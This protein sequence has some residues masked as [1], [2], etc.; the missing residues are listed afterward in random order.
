MQH[1]KINFDSNH[2]TNSS[3]SKVGTDAVCPNKLIYIL[4]YTHER[5]YSYV[6]YQYVILRSDIR[7][8]I[9]AVLTQQ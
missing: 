9:L 2:W 3:V 1:E 4:F 8:R 7:N 6:P 5:V